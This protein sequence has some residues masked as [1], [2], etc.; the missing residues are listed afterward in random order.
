MVFGLKNTRGE[1]TIYPII[2]LQTI[3][4]R[5]LGESA[6]FD[7]IVVSSNPMSGDDKEACATREE[8]ERALRTSNLM[9]ANLRDELLQLAAQV[10]T[11]SDELAERGSIDAEKVNEAVSETHKQVQA[12]DILAMPLSVD[13]GEPT[14]DKYGLP[15]LDVPCEEL[16][17]L[18]KARCCKLQFALSTQDLNEGKV[19]WNYGRP[20]W[21]RQR[22]EDGYCVHNDPQ[23]KGCQV[24]GCRPGP[25][26]QFDCR[27]DPRIW[28][29]YPNRI[30]ASETQLDNHRDGNGDD[31]ATTRRDALMAAVGERKTARMIE[32]WSVLGD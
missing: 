14:V 30:P 23:T 4:G 24:Y 6:R 18:C 19:R 15:G 9:I 2:W 5:A 3:F 27:E 26:R 32:E 17:H 31:D 29:D 22:D 28:A 8:L 20:Y 1:A 7:E 11:L 10:V 21:I 16:M 13:Y 25:C 12:A